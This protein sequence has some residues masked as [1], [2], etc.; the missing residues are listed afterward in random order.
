[1]P[2]RPDKFQVAEMPGQARYLTRKDG[3]KPLQSEPRFHTNENGDTERALASQLGENPYDALRA[4]VA[5][6]VTRLVGPDGTVWPGV[7]ETDKG[8]Q[9]D[10]HTDDDLVEDLQQNGFKVLP[11]K[12]LMSAEDTEASQK[13]KDRAF[14]DAMRIKG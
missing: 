4:N 8:F 6:G 12:G 7:G 5:K 13:L 2:D 14:I 1:M 9:R 3:S 11:G 10:I